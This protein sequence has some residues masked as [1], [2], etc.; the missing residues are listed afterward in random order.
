MD[1]KPVSTAIP[2]VPPV[3]ISPEWS[4]RRLFSL[5]WPL[6]TEQL[7]IVS[8]GMADMIMVSSVGEHAV[9]GVSFV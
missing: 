3:L 8:M 5:L 2:V 1:T 9:S 6:I 4:N 7:L